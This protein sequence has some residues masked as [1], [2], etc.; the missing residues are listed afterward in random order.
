MGQIS[1]FL[2]YA[3]QYTKPFN[4]VTGIITQ[5]QAALASAQRV[6]AVLDE[7]SEPEDAADAVVPDGCSGQISIEDVSFSYDPNRPLIERMNLS[8]KPGQR[9]AI[10]GPT[11]CGKTTLI[12][13]LMRFYDVDS[14]RIFIDGTEIRGMTRNGMRSLFGMVLQGTAIWSIMTGSRGRWQSVFRNFSGM[15]KR[16]MIWRQNGLRMRMQSLQTAPGL[17]GKR[18]NAV[19]ICGISA[20]L[21]PDIILSILPQPG[22]GR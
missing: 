14:G 16:R 10:V 6:F 13:L 2:S 21:E 22:N 20:C 4:A 3:Q 11:G 15:M 1:M 9:I 17:A 18:W 5:L 12:N 8:V 7:P 19:R